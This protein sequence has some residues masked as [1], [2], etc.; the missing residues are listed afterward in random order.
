MRAHLEEVVYP[1]IEGNQTVNERGNIAGQDCPVSLLELPRRHPG[2]AGEAFR[3]VMVIS[4]EHV[5]PEPAALLDGRLQLQREQFKQHRTLGGSAVN[6]V[7]G[8]RD[9][10]GPSVPVPE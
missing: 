1:A 5:H 4:T 3:Q 10:S 9:P 2:H 7:T 8:S 6:D